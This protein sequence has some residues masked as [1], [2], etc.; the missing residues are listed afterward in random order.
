MEHWIGFF[1]RPPV[2][3][4]V[5]F[6]VGRCVP[7]DHLWFKP[8]VNRI[9]FVWSLLKDWIL[10]GFYLNFPMLSAATTISNYIFTQHCKLTSMPLHE[11]LIRCHWV[12]WWTFGSSR[13]SGC[14]VLLD[15][16]RVGLIGYPFIWNS[17][18]WYPD[19]CNCIIH[20]SQRTV[21]ISILKKKDSQNIDLQIQFIK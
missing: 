10:L 17:N 13:S 7:A 11:A 4:D 16:M 18:H 19:Y 5:V 6:Q 14:N 12:P 21:L 15:A 8:D 3:M 2:W 20:R 1:K 9:G